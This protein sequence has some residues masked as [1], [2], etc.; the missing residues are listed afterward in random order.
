MKKYQNKRKLGKHINCFISQNAKEVL[1]R[2]LK[3]KKLNITE[4]IENLILELD[5][6][7]ENL[8][9]R[10]FYESLFKV[11]SINQHVYRE[12]MANSNNLNQL[13]KNTNIAIKYNKPFYLQNLTFLEELFKV[14]D[15]LNKN[16]EDCKKVSLELLLQIYKEQKSQ[17]EFNAISK[18]LNALNEKQSITEPKKDNA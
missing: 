6:N 10:D 5:P 17:T 12:L 16:V 9:A 15:T 14:M 13:T 8:K 2:Y 4:C 3:S 18:V 1:E 7:K 11:I